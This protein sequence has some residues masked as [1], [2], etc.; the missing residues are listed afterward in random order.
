[1]PW[2]GRK[3]DYLTLLIVGIAGFLNGPGWLLLL[4][5]AALS[6]DDCAKLWLQWRNGVA[7]RSKPMTYVVTGAFS[8]LGYAALCYL[9][10]AIIALAV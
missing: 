6:I 8:N 7:I 1:M 9:A 10:G 2:H 5:A 3:L 4:A